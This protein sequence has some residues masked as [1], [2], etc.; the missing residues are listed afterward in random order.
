MGKLRWYKRDPVAALEGMSNLTLEECGA[1]N[2]VLDLIY[3]RDGAVDDDDRFIAGWLRCDVRVWRRIRARLIDLKKLYVDAGSLRNSRADREVDRGLSMV[4]SAS[5]AGKASAR[6]READKSKDKN[7]AET[8]VASTASTNSTP[9]TTASSSSLRSDE[10]R[11]R[12]NVPR[13]TSDWP[14][15]A[16]DQFWRKYPH[17]VGKQAAL[18]AF[19]AAKRTGV[20]WARVMFALDRYIIEKPPDRAWCNPATWLNQGRWDDEPALPATST[21]PPARAPQPSFREI[22]DQL[23][24]GP[25]HE[26]PAI[27][28]ADC[29]LELTAGEGGHDEFAGG[30]FG[31]HQGGGHR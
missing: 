24:G 14:A 15:D 19:A 1:Y 18:K 26:E 25:H 2:K 12:K 10:S 8:P 5:E 16:F 23:R 21:G 20:P 3:A 31:G 4:A 29:D 27:Q 13:E 7:L 6:K 9:T 17:K 28:P 30:L 22:A 11:A